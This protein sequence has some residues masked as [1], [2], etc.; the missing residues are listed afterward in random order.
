[1]TKLGCHALSVHQAGCYIKK[2]NITLSEFLGHYDREREEVMSW[3][4]TIWSYVKPLRED[5]E[6][7][8]AF[9]VFTTFQLA[10]DAMPYDQTTSGKIRRF[11]EICSYLAINR[12]SDTLFLTSMAD[13][14]PTLEL[15]KKPD[16]T[17]NKSEFESVILVLREHGL[18]LLSTPARR[19]FA[20]HPLI[21]DW[22]KVKKGA[23]KEDMKAAQLENSMFA[24]RIVRNCLETVV[25][26]L[27]RRYLNIPLEIRQEILP[28]VMACEELVCQRSD[29]HCASQVHKI[30]ETFAEFLDSCGINDLAQKLQEAA[31]K[32]LRS[33]PDTE[34][35]TLTTSIRLLAKI[36]HHKGMDTKAEEL[37][38]ERLKALDFSLEMGD[39]STLTLAELFTSALCYQG[40]FNDAEKI[41]ERVLAIRKVHR[42]NDVRGLLK[43]RAMLAWIWQNSHKIEQAETEQENILSER[44]NTFG[45]DDLDT[46][47]S[48]NAQGC[49]YLA[50]GKLAKAEASLR[51]AV[52]GRK[53]QLGPTHPSTLNALTNLSMVVASQGHWKEAVSMSKGII[54]D[55]EERLGKNHI[56]TLVSIA[57][58]LEILKYSPKDLFPQDE[59]TRL[60]TRL[61]EATKQGLLEWTT[62]GGAPKT[63]GNGK[64]RFE[65]RKLMRN[66]G[67]IWRPNM[68]VEQTRN[69][70]SQQQQQQ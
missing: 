27:P 11:L 47:S 56:A 22:L 13:D 32:A 1:V 55:R 9:S 58:L 2:N 24:A 21:A 42:P 37:L 61:E 66:I 3:T 15:F 53:K 63:A 39:P 59:A 68:A 30:C 60:Q 26:D 29:A 12:I 25:Q 52:E 51:K 7:Q 4:P 67:T 70:R 40:K 8:V 41:G 14:I 23:S 44:V 33:I 46:L 65:R 43:C 48:F 5:D 64:R 62:P 35:K 16:G 17:W 6:K 57:N 20:I 36:Y 10:F 34:D 28:H 49:V 69:F 54:E 38:G 50:Q 31:I 18:V 19:T 45:E